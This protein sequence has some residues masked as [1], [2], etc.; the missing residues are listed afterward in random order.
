M[1]KAFTFTSA[2]LFLTIKQVKH[3][4]KYSTTDLCIYIWLLI[5]GIQQPPGAHFCP[6]QTSVPE[7]KSQTGPYIKQEI[8]FRY[9]GSNLPSL[10]VLEAAH[11]GIASWSGSGDQLGSA[12]WKTT[13]GSSVCDGPGISRST[14]V[15][16][17]ISVFEPAVQR[18]GEARHR[19][20]S[21]G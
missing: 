3:N 2:S 9:P 14:I 17:Q 10:D 6:P 21:A 12:V 1:S 20:V 16:K 5:C 19:A 11:Y 7:L 18:T 4:K 13:R 15:S 8:S